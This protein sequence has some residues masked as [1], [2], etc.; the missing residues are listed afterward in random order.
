MNEKFVIVSQPRSGTTFFLSTISTNKELFCDNELFNLSSIVRLNG[1]H[2]NSEIK[3]VRWRDKNPHV[4][5]DNFYNSNFAKQHKTIGFN[6]MLGHHPEVLEKIINDPEIKIIYLKRTNRLAQATSWFKAL[7]TKEWA[8]NKSNSLSEKQHFN[9]FRYLE[10]MRKSETLDYLFEA[11]IK[12]RNNV[13][14]I[15]YS[16]FANFKEVLNKVSKFLNVSNSFSISNLKKQGDNHIIKRFS[17]PKLVE[18]VISNINKLN[19]LDKEI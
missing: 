11:A 9:E 14:K 4:L 10:F 8:T 12:D 7:D 15:E 16:N 2:S 18:D 5:F 6:F 13:L 19:W 17:N 1:E 3:A